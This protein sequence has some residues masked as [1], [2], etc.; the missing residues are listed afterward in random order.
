M[1]RSP[2]LLNIW[3][4]SQTAWSTPPIPPRPRPPCLLF[5]YY[6]PFS[7]PPVL[8]PYFASVFIFNSVSLP[9]AL[10]LPLVRTY[11][12]VTLHPFV[13][14]G[15]FALF[16]TRVL[17]YSALRKW[18]SVWALRS[19][20]LRVL[21]NPLG[22]I[23]CVE[24]SFRAK[25]MDLFLFME[26]HRTEMTWRLTADRTATKAT[27]VS[28][29]CPLMPNKT[30]Y[31]LGMKM[32]NGTAAGKGK[33]KDGGQRNLIE[34]RSG[35]LVTPSN[36]TWCHSHLISNLWRGCSR[37]GEGGKKSGHCLLPGI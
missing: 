27:T 15:M 26:H 13:I 3:K 34:S 31:N 30:N 24:V 21:I 23:S 19:D 22:V 32:G 11:V 17:Y 12:A 7:I 4:Q 25:T 29:V 5:I 37:L 16:S 1:F 36:Q 9:L 8:Q 2:L 6:T 10:T 14:A 35:R 33:K 20:S 28:S 18:K